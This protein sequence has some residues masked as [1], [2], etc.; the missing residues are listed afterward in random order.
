MQKTLCSLLSFVYSF[1]I[2]LA[3]KTLA[4]TLI[5][6]EV[7]LIMEQQGILRPD[8]GGILATAMF[9][10]QIFVGTIVLAELVKQATNKADGAYVGFLL[11]LAFSLPEVTYFFFANI[12]WPLTVV[13]IVSNI[14]AFS[15]AGFVYTASK[16]RQC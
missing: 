5:L 14:V 1:V 8:Q 4:Y 3:V 11:G 2:S 13:A 6:K 15:L 7:L 16:L 10:V 9:A 12:Q